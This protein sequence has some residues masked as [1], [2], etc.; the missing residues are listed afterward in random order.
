MRYLFTP[1]QMAITKK[2]DNETGDGE[3]TEELESS[4]TA[5]GN[6]NAAAI[7]ESKLAIPQKGKHKLTIL[8]SNSILRNLFKKNENICPYEDL[9]ATVTS[10]IIHHSQSE[11]DL[12]GHQL[13]NR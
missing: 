12:N 5:G 2:T 8:F 6:A 7:L 10:S 11:D 9:Y 4:Y 3:D 13:T 1:N